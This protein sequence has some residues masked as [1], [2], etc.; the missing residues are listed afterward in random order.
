[1]LVYI[2]NSRLASYSNSV[3]VPIVIFSWPIS[4]FHVHVVN[5]QYIL[6]RTIFLSSDKPAHEYMY[7]ARVLSIADSPVSYDNK[8]E[9]AMSVLSP[10]VYGLAIAIAILMLLLVLGFLTENNRRKNF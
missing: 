8:G 3:S 4:N 7:S 9:I 5:I 10:T 1:M 6:R 2:N